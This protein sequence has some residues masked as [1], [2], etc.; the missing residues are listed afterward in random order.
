MLNATQCFLIIQGQVLFIY[1]LICT[2]LD[3]KLKENKTNVRQT[4]HH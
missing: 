1:L 2:K 3:I 4:Q